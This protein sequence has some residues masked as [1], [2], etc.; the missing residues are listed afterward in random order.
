[1]ILVVAV[2]AVFAVLPMAAAQT[3]PSARLLGNGVLVI[4]GE[5]DADLIVARAE[6]P[7]DLTVEVDASSWTFA[8]DQVTGIRVFAGDG[9]DRVRIFSTLP[10]WSLMG[11]DVD[12]G[13]G[14]RDDGRI[15]VYNLSTPNALTVTG[16]VTS[17]GGGITLGAG[18]E[19]VASTFTVEG[20]VT[21]IGGP[22]DDSLGLEA[23]M[24]PGTVRVLGDVKFIGGEGDDYA[25]LNANGTITIEGRFM[26]L[27]QG[28]DEYVYLGGQT[29]GTV[30]GDTKLFGGPG[31]DWLDLEHFTSATLTVKK[32]ET[33]EGAGCP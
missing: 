15:S 31:D 17:R 19:T 1:L 9:D 5:G 11:I 16:N 18:T 23:E 10:S 25:E 27:C 28:G 24:T 7:N 22:G 4:E 12:F 33:C 30:L 8:A 3:G 14:L 6:S 2:V 32:F 26:V 13:E 20:N 29:G 21:A